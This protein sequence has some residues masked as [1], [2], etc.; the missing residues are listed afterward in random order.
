[1]PSATGRRV[2]VGLRGKPRRRPSFCA[3]R[4]RAALPPR[5][6]RRAAAPAMLPRSLRKR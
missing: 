6:V 1:M 2:K 3:R 5:G 4:W